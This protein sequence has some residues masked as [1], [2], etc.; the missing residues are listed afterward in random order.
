MQGGIRIAVALALLVGV[1]GVGTVGFAAIEGWSLIDSIYMAV[2]TVSTVGFTEVETLSVEGRLWAIGLIVLAVATLGY[3][4]STIIAYL[5]EGQFAKDVRRRRMT[6]ALSKIRDH[7]IICGGG[8]FGREV[9]AEL[10]RAAVPFA[11]VDRDP[12]S[13][14]LAAASDEGTLFVSGDCEDDATLMSAGIDRARGLISA[15]PEDDSNAFVVMTA[16]QLNPDMVVISQ[17][18]D[19]RSIKKLKLAG[20]DHVVSPYRSAG[21]RMASLLVR[22]SVVNFL[23]EALDVQQT[24]MQIDEVAVRD[25]SPVEGQ[26]LANCG[27]GAATGAVVLAIHGPDGTRLNP[28]EA[29]TLGTVTLRTN[30]V[31][32]AVGTEEQLQAL[33]D[34][35]EAR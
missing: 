14:E 25:G 1:I 32:V 21:R 12:D 31:L 22:P 8:K 23:E 28:A 29:A 17:A 24:S 2:I 13:S 15:L 18:A 19:E 6:R 11:V 4:V 30:D 10:G 16:R 3:S 34:F 5:F 35:V 9:A 20:A 33:R 7:A 26:R 27:V